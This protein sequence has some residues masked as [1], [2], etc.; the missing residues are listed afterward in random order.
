MTTFIEITFVSID[1]GEDQV[2]CEGQP[3]T[4]SA[5]GGISYNW[6]NSVQ[7]AVPFV[8]TVS[9]TYTVSGTDINGCVAEDEV[10]VD[11]ETNPLINPVIEQDGNCAPTTVSFS[12]PSGNGVS[13]VW[14]LSNGVTLTGNPVSYTFEQGGTFGVSVTAISSAGCN[15]TFEANNFITIGSGTIA[16]FVVNPDEITTLNPT[17]DLFNSSSNAS[18]YEWIFPD[19]STSNESNPSFT[20]PED[21]TGNYEIMLITSN[22]FGCVD[23]AIQLVTVLEELIFYVPNTFTPDGDIYNQTFK[24]VFTS[25]FDPYDYTLYVYNRWGEIVFESHNAEIG[26]DGSYS[27]VNGSDVCQCQDGTYT[28]KIIFKLSWSDERKVAVGHV[29]L[30]R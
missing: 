1:A 10:L 3:V 24:P 8:P 2:I 25:G 19:G 22:E 29:N 30:L 17:V 13:H 6:S 18:E 14:Y 12:N 26:W 15:G 20:F 9:T 7:N 11:V 28:W 27:G 4:L 21:Q 23:T 5:S 16:D